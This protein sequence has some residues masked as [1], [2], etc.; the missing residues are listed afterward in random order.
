MRLTRILQTVVCLTAAAS[1]PAFG[2]FFTISSPTP[3][4]L[5]NTSLLG[6]PVGASFASV[7][8]AQSYSVSPTLIQFQVPGSWTVWGAPPDTESATPRVLAT[9]INTTTVTWTLTPGVTTFGFEIEPANAGAVP[10]PLS[11]TI[12]A[13][14]FNGATPL[15]TI[16][17]SLQ[18]NAARVFAASSSTPITSV[19]ITAPLAAGGFAMAQ[20]RTGSTLIGGPDVTA[21]PALGLPE[22]GALSLLLAGAGVLLARRQQAA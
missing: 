21:I 1:A 5:G 18:Y 4:Y 22:L 16:S 12:T 9:P 3:Q 19:V 6:I 10:T 20:L 14:Y 2:Q 11:Y 17:R 15:G 13:T 7:S 8:G